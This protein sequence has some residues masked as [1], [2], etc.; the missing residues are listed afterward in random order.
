MTGRPVTFGARR[1][2][3]LPFT[4]F[5]SPF[6]GSQNPRLS[7][8]HGGDEYWGLVQAG[9][10]RSGLVRTG[11]GGSGLVQ[12]CP[13]RSRLGRREQNAN[14]TPTGSQQD[15][16]RTP[17][18]RQQDA[19]RGDRGRPGRGSTRAGPCFGA[20]RPHFLRACREFGNRAFAPAVSLSLPPS[21]S[22]SESLRIRG[23]SMG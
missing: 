1:S 15:A 5:Y 7:Q 6:M 13:G 18:G 19:S 17:T 22:K 16:N 3:S 8:N 10:G 2:C 21:L 14:R 20:S 11:P 12:T 4:P 23:E 9:P